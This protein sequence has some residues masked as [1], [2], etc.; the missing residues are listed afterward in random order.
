MNSHNLVCL[1]P[2]LI[3]VVFLQQ[4][5]SGSMKAVC[6]WLTD[7]LDLQLHMYQLKTLIK[8]VKVNKCLKKSIT[9]DQS[10]CQSCQTA[11]ECGD[12]P[13]PNRAACHS[14]QQLR[15]SFQRL[16]FSEKSCTER[17]WDWP[18]WFVLSSRKHLKLWLIHVNTVRNWHWRRERR[19]S[20]DKPQVSLSS[21]SSS[22]EEVAKQGGRKLLNCAAARHFIFCT[23]LLMYVC[24]SLTWKLRRQGMIIAAA[25][26]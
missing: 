24:A 18:S 15:S 2:L 26:S 5:Y 10:S 25:W 17:A 20:K 12:A 13:L 6:V 4:W 11:N 19:K 14:G 22:C 1:F 7:R 23:V 8:I 16:R 9:R 3:D 21:S